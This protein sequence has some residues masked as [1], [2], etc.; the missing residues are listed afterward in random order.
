MFLYFVHDFN[1]DLPLSTLSVAK[2]PLPILFGT[3][4]TLAGFTYFIFSYSFKS[5]SQN[6]HKV[7][8]FSGIALGLTGW[9]PYR[10][11]GGAQDI[12]HSMCIYMAGMGYATMI[13][14]MKAHPVRAAGKISAAAFWLLMVAAAIGFISLFIVHKYVAFAQLGILLLIQVWTIMIV[15][16]TRPLETSHS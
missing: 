12:A 8:L 10:G 2:Q 7:A 16:Q 14:M 4:L 13:W 15:W 11:T 6:I 5:H 9:I 1:P 3:T